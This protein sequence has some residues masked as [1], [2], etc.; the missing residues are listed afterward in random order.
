MKTFQNFY[1]TW[2]TFDPKTLKAT[3][4]YSFDHEVYFTEIIDFASSELKAIST[5]DTEVM[6]T[7]LFH[8]SLALW[9]SYYKLYPTKDLV[10][11]TGSLNQDQQ[12]FWKNFYT[13]GLG[14]FFYT[15]KLSPKG[16][17]NFVNGTQKT[18]QT[19]FS[20]SSITPMVALGWGKDSLVSVEAIKKLNIPFYT[21]TFGK[22]YYLH[23]VVGDTTWAPR[24]VMKRTMDPKLFE[25]NQQWWYNGHVP[26][27]GIIG[28]VLVTA[29]YLYEYRY[30][31]MSNEKSANEGNTSLDG[32]EINHQRSKSYQFESDFNSYIW[33]YLYPDVYYFS[34]LRGMYE[35]NIAKIFTQYQ[36]YFGI[37]SSCN[38]NFKIIE[39]N[40]TTDH[41]RCGVCPKCAFVYTTL[42]PFISDDDAQ[43]IFGQELYNN[44]DLI[45]LYKELLGIQWIKPFECVGT[46]EEVT[47]AMYLQYEKIK[48]IAQIPPIM[49]L[50]KN[51]ILHKLSPNDLLILEKK[52]FMLYT[53]ETNIPKIF[54][55]IFSP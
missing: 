33:K 19:L 8:L 2:Y 22:D 11:E 31:I 23:K 32:I 14:E 4:S 12:S 18:P 21:S 3:F 24:L 44:E 49:K 43:I 38:N 51:E 25:M 45:P 37:F 34:L 10:V 41:R 30:I 20:T 16:L 28:F 1:F 5:I 53:E 27:S 52:L 42:R 7:L 26:I 48:H 46:N 15:N 47:Y 9:I 39:S 36:Q 50:F 6:N 54:Q 40:K 13:Q 35:I 17:I 55:S 29:A